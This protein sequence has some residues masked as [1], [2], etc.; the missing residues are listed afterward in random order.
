MDITSKYIAMCVTASEIQEPWEPK[1][2][3]F[4]WDSAGLVYPLS[5]NNVKYYY[6]D[7]ERISKFLR[8]LPRQDQ[9]QDMIDIRDESECI[10][11][12]KLHSFDYFAMENWTELRTYEQLWLGFVM[13]DLYGKVWRDKWVSINTQ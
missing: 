10:D 8:W 7:K 11:L 4:I 5:S 3:D 12:W 13:Q 1:M 9:L 2:G 6:K